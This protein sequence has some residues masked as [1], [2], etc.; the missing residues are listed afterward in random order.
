VENEHKTE[1][2]VAHKD[3]ISA[4]EVLSGVFRN[5]GIDLK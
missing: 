2:L 1:N 5:L 4:I 3:E